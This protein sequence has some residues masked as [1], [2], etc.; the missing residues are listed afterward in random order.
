MS[1]KIL[2][3]TFQQAQTVTTSPPWNQIFHHC[4]TLD[5]SL[6]VKRPILRNISYYLIYSS[7]NWV[8]WTSVAKFVNIKYCHKNGICINLRSISLVVSKELRKCGEH[9]LEFQAMI[10]KGNLST[11][12]KILYFRPGSDAVLHMSRIEF[13]FRSTQI[14]SDR[15]N[16]FRRRS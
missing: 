2:R 14:N 3:W 6:W 4:T 13:E 11:R 7:Q 9:R 10:E 15:L 12:R 8:F 16:W 5:D 1:L